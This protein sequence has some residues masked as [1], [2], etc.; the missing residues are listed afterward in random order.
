[1]S[2]SESEVNNSQ[3]NTEEGGNV[4]NPENFVSNRKFKNPTTIEE[5]NEMRAQ[6]KQDHALKKRDKEEYKK[7]VQIESQGRVYQPPQDL[8]QFKIL[9]P[10]NSQDTILSELQTS[11]NDTSTKDI[12]EQVF[13]GEN[14]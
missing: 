10:K 9:Q 6:I 5:M 14:S 3:Q 1:M 13:V 11:Q 7:K 2:T 8:K 4:I 12:S